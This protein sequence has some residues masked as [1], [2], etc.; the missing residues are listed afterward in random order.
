MYADI[1]FEGEPLSQL[2]PTTQDEVRKIIMRSQSCEL[3]PL[4]TG[5][6]KQCLEPLLPMITSIMNKSLEESRVPLWFKKAN[7]R[8]LLKKSGLEKENLKNYRPVS[9]LQFLSKVLEKIVSNRLETHLLAYDLHDNLQSAYRTGHSTE[10]ALIRVFNDIAVA[11]DQKC[12]AALVMLDLSAAFDTIDH[13]ILFNRMEYSYGLSGNA[14]SWIQSYLSERRQRI[15]I[16]S[17]T[18][19]ETN[20]DFGVPQGSV[21]G[22]RIYCL[23]SKPVG[24]ICR[25]HGFQYHCYADDTQIYMVIKPQDS[26][27][28]ISIRLENCISDISTWMNASMLKLKQ[29]KTEL[30]VFSPKGQQ[31]KALQLRVGDK[32]IETTEVVKNLGVHFDSSLTM[33]KQVNCIAK[34]CYYQIRNIGRIRQYITTDACKTLVH[35]LVTSRLDYGNALL[36]GISD[37]LTCRLQRVQNTAARLITCTRKKEHITPVLH[38]LHWLP[39]RYRPQYKILVNTY[40]AMNGTAPKYLQE[41]VTPYQPLRTLRSETESLVCVPKTRTATYGNRCFGKVAAS[42]WNGF[43]STIRKADTLAIFKKRVKTHLFKTAF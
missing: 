31:R 16:G 30:I 25:R 37:M 39:V 35:S 27:D 41:L 4:P 26:L 3:D 1:L 2:A 22:P 21:L 6:L 9:N 29:E 12:T 13:D 32:S 43:P 24:E 19:E 17:T 40:K 11:L 20:L 7:V 15:A 14:L 28:T 18:S 36:C 10:T 38:S 42:L 34:S 33:E 5:L 23:Y 8:P